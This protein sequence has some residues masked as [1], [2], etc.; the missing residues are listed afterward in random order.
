MRLRRSF[1]SL[2]IVS[3]LAVSGAT[4]A[5][6]QNNSHQTG[7]VNIS[8]GNV[9][10]L[11]RV[12]LA[13]AANVAATVCPQAAVPVGVLAQ[14]V[15]AQS[16]SFTCDTI[17][18][19]LTIDQALNG[20]GGQPSAGG[21]NSRQTGLV[22]VSVGDVAILNDVNAAVAANI[23]ATACPQLAIPIAVLAAQI[24]AQE[25]EFTCSTLAGPLEVTQS[26]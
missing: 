5:S 11:N 21:N 22:N 12:N 9:D 15:V 19:P 1:V 14:Q 6:A 16:G 3:L 2:L 20:P 4:A 17:A 7:L 23:A 8:L 13:L 18:G 25:G 24:V 26:Q 10:L